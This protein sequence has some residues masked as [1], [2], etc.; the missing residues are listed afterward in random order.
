MFLLL[1]HCKMVFEISDNKFRI[2]ENNPME[3]W[4]ISD[5][6]FQTWELFSELR[7]IIV[8]SSFA[9]NSQKFLVYGQNSVEVKVQII[10]I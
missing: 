1:I 9:I 10:L 7:Q 5:N 6:K 8:F 2:W 4:P 3:K